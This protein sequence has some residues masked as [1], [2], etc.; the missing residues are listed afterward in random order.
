[1]PTPAAARPANERPDGLLCRHQAS[2]LPSGALGVHNQQH[3]SAEER[4]RSNNGRDKVVDGGLDVHSEE[5]DRLSRSRESD[6]RISEHHDA[7]GDQED[8][9]YGFCIHIDSSVFIFS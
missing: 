9:N 5:L 6:A 7:K 3:D 4:K 1:M 8:R 2:A